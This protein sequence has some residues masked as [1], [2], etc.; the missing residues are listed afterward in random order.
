MNQPV[1]VCA[2]SSLTEGGRSRMYTKGL[3]LCATA[4]MNINFILGSFIFTCKGF[5]YAFK[6]FWIS[7]SLKNMPKNLGKL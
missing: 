4:K 3:T 6:A 7:I 1:P 5:F 2:Q